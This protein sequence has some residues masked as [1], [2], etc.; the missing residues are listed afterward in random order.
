LA[1][2]SIYD[3]GSDDKAPRTWLTDR[4]HLPYL[5]P[6]L[7]FGIV[8]S[9]PLLDTFGGG[10]FWAD[11]WKTYHPAVYTAKTILAAVLLCLF[12]KYYKN[13]R[14]THL[15]TG[16]A[17][18]LVGVPL[19]IYLE[20]WAQ[21]AG[22]SQP[23]DKTNFHSYYN[24]DHEIA[25]PFMR[26]LFLF[27]RVAGPT[28]VVPIMEELV[29]RDFLMRAFIGGVRFD[30]V[31]PGTFHKNDPKSWLAIFGTAA[32][33][34]FSHFQRPSAFV[35]AVMMGFLMVRTKSLGACIVAHGVTNL[36]LYLF[37]IYKGDI[38]WQ[39]M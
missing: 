8:M 32:I 30:D 38:Y 33:F 2:R 3:A 28:L 17:V 31:E 9:G 29:Y 13:I 23:F 5:I 1:Q 22:I 36:A 12:W 16:V 11:L 20:L 26:F 14:W 6:L 7:A 10:T 37:V 35:W 27:V 39:F 34:T 19:W 4:P 18:G 21:S 15:G 25:D 24:P